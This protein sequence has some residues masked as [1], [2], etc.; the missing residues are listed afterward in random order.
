MST[1]EIEMSKCKSKICIIAIILSVMFLL[2]GCSA[3]E[4]LIE[5]STSPS[6]KYT[7]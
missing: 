4:E 5:E 1:G 2:S 6:G 7:V 3:S